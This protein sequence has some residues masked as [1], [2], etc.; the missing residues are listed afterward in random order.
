M[1]QIRQA[2]RLTA[3]EEP[4]LTVRSLATGY[5]SGYVIDEHAHG[6]HQLLY[7]RTG[8]M[9]V[10]AGRSC[11]MLTP[12]RAVLI[13]AGC[14]HSIRMWGLA[15]MRTLYFAPELRPDVLGASE[16]RVLTAGPLLREIIVRITQLSALDSRRA[17]DERL[18]G[19]LFD[20][21]AAAPL[22]DLELL[23]P[24]DPAA[25]ALAQHIVDHPASDEPLDALARRCAIG[26]RTAER[27]F[28][29]ET[30]MSLG[31]WRQKARLLASVH[32]LLA[33]R[34]V[35]EAAFEAGYASVSAFIAAFRRTF[36]CTPGEL[37]RDGHAAARPE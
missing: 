2:R 35:T 1:S 4:Y 33:D 15:A 17:G 30:G 26:T 34:P 20:E 36:G 10:Y 22:T 5:A 11:R 23:M 3:D 12:G 13:P 6:W 28:R 16:C 7:A 9:T 27:R 25:R 19:V 14:V 21:I 29:D 37:A 8:A 31:L 24:E 32:V 18:L